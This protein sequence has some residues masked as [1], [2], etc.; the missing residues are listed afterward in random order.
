MQLLDNKTVGKNLFAFREETSLSARAFA[1]KCSV[2]PSQYNKIENGELPLTD[3]IFDKIK[4]AY[5]KINKSEILGIDVPQETKGK[6]V[7]QP[8]I[9][10]ANYLIHIF[11]YSRSMFYA[12]LCLRSSL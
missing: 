8:G 5:P 7:R 6:S 12:P 9:T 2:D 1:L 4:A 11:H 3:N 10:N